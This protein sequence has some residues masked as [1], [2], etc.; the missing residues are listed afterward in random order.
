MS[1]TLKNVIMILLIVLLSIALLFTIKPIGMGIENRERNLERFQG[2]EVPEGEIPTKPDGEMPEMPEGQKAPAK[3][4][5]EMPGDANLQRQNRNEKMELPE[6]MEKGDFRK[7]TGMR[8]NPI[9]IVLCAIE[10]LGISVLVMY[11]ILSK[12]NKLGL[13]ETFSNKSSIICYIIIVI[14]LTIIITF[15]SMFVMRNSYRGQNF[16]G[17]MMPQEEEIER[18]T[19]KEDVSS[20]EMVNAE[21]INL[22]DHTSNIT[23]DKAGAYNLSGEFSNTL[24]I[25]ADGEVILNFNNVVIKNTVTAAF[26]N[27]STNPVTINLVDGTNNVLSDGGSSEYDACVYSAGHL[28][29][30]GNGNLEVYG[31]QEEGEGIATETNDLTISG[32][33]ITVE[34]NDDG[35]NAGGDGGTI[36]VSG[37]KLLVKAS[38]DG[39]D[40]NKNIKITGGEVYAIGSAKGGD[41]GLDADEGVAIDGGDVVAIGSDM[42]EKPKETSKQKYVAANLS[43]KVAVGSKVELKDSNSNLIKEFEAKEEFKTIIIS[44]E[45]IEKGTYTLYIDGEKIQDLD[46]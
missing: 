28:T 15:I 5:G 32:G 2:E 42:L 12:F 23:I 39:I 1:R 11:L 34:A 43:K 27:I 10:A 36:L 20:G 44:N 38:G 24:L 33:N 31:N 18:T 46:V 35:L 13:K 9:Q 17:G 8:N 45:K 26:A 19:K 4:D 16:R 30:S 37:G 7:A 40:S 29:I 41:A 22:A 6:G 25:N 14:L 21:E 3:P